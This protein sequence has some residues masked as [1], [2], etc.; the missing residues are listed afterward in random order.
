M[1]KASVQILPGF[2]LSLAAAILL[3]PL[4]WLFAWML[5]AVIHELFHF[6]AVFLFRYSVLSVTIGAGGA[7]I[8]TDMTPGLKMTVCA[9][10]GPVGGLLLLLFL[11]IAPRLALCG[12]IQS[13]YNLLPLCH[14]DGGRA[15]YGIFLSLFQPETA[16]QISV[17]V[18]RV[19]IFVLVI[20]AVY[21]FVVLHL[22]I[23]PL[24]FVSVLL[25]K[26][27]KFLANKAS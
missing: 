4:P 18:E 7:K 23:I 25:F 12:L 22:G 14:L 5:A 24:F 2:F 20:A 26:N 8:E 3:I 13:L 6:L 17:I 19:I 10:A 16:E 27:K 1:N 9:L 11:R 15:L 21:A